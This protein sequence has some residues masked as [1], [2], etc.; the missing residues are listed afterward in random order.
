MIQDIADLL[1]DT[2]DQLQLV[3]QI[4][5]KSARQGAQDQRLKPRI[6]NVLENQ[7]SI[8]D[9][10]A[11]HIHDRYG[12]PTDKKI[13]YPLARTPANFPSQC[14]QRMPGV[15]KARPDIAGAI[16]RCQPYNRIWLLW[17]TKLVNDHKH[18]VLTKHVRH[19][20]TRTHLAAPGG[21]TM[22][23][24]GVSFQ[25]EHGRPIT[26]S[27]YFGVPSHDEARIEWLLS[28]DATRL[29][30]WIV[31]RMIQQDLVPAVDGIIQV[32]GL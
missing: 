31:L 12:I 24:Q 19:A 1:A 2:E 6:K 10:L 4:Y 20:T 16:E 27:E 3:A 14:D 5:E 18:R 11:H 21:G 28:V 15:R 9:Y 17:L 13:Y 7:R 30:A 8:L 29:P 23:V 26:P 25:D 22:T 32:A